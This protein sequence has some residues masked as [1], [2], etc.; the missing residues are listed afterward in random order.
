MAA[1]FTCACAAPEQSQQVA[2]GPQPLSSQTGGDADAAEEGPSWDLTR[3]IVVIPWTT[4]FEPRALLLADNVR[5][6]GPVGLLEH[7]ATGFE[8]QHHSRS[9]ETRPE[10][11]VQTVQIRHAAAPHI[12]GKLDGLDIVAQ[13]SLV[14]IERPG[15]VDVKVIATGEA[16]WSNPGTGEEQRG[17]A[18]EFTGQIERDVVEPP[19][20]EQSSG[21]PDP[22]RE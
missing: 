17:D 20:L 9:V 2:A 4:A 15:A 6:E 7:F 16:Y 14:V 8:Q 1:L 5:V 13:H 19:D 11:F 21:A 12:R 3:E 18:L 22:V 10:G